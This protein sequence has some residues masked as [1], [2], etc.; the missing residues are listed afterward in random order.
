MSN[1]VK[2]QHYIPQSVLMHF[3]KKGMVYECLL[4]KSK[5]SFKTNY[6]NSMSERFTYEHPALEENELEKFFQTIEDEYAPAI[7]ETIRLIELLELE[8]GSIQ[9]IKDYYQSFLT[10]AIIYYYRSGALL[11][12]FSFETKKREDRISMLMDKLRRA[13]YITQ[14]AQTISKFYQFAIIKSTESHFLISDQYISTVALRIKSRF[15]DI[16]NRHMGLKDVMILIPIS[17]SYYL[18]YYDGQPP[19][20]IYPNKVN[21]LTPDEV[22]DV[23]KIIINNSY[24]KCVGREKSAVDC[25]APFYT[26]NS[27]STV[28][29]GYNSGQHSGSTLKKEVFYYERDI[30]AWDM[31]TNSPSELRKYDRLSRNNICA[32]GSGLKF[33]NC[34]IS[35]IKEVHRIWRTIEKGQR[36]FSEIKVDASAVVE[37]S[38]FSFSG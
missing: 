27:P 11:H 24:I 31:F 13:K 26:W 1:I 30:K 17:S 8:N 38:I 25:A 10:T 12:E 20:Y 15:A 5:E 37:K 35:Y 21:I 3:S 33:K 23:N 18:V 7:I 19:Y 14:L 9:A 32:C 6:R 16:S 2:N 29:V 28:I 22:L 36:L 4:N 34:C